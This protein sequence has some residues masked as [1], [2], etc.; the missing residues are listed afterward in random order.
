MILIVMSY[1]YGY[2][3]M[4]KKFI[5]HPPKPRQGSILSFHHFRF[6]GLKMREKR[7]VLS[8]ITQLSSMSLFQAKKFPPLSTLGHVKAH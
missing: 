4:E 2:D 6:K 7:K 8:T 3:L 5:S 1:I